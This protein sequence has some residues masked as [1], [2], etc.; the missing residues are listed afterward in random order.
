MYGTN[1]NG[2][3]LKSQVDS[4]NVFCV[5]FIKCDYSVEERIFRITCS[6]SRLRRQRCHPPFLTS[7][8]R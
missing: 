7:H 5:T 2:V 1:K 6:Y 3:I 8:S 4:N